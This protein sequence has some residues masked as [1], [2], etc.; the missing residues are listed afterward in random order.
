MNQE[1]RSSQVNQAAAVS[2]LLMAALFLLPLL[3]A[4]PGCWTGRRS[5][6]WTWGPI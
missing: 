6:R 1:R 4:R 2:A 3:A 5:W